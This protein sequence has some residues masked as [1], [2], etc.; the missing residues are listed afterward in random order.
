MTKR[1][2]FGIC[3]LLGLGVFM[4][5]C[6]IIK[7]VQ[8][9][10]IR[11]S[12]D[13]TCKLLICLFGR[14]LLTDFVERGIAQL[15]D[16]VKVSIPVISYLSSPPPALTSSKHRNVG[17]HHHPKHTSSLASLSPSLAIVH[18]PLLHPNKHPNAQ[19]INAA[20]RPHTWSELRHRT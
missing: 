4:G 19:Q 17:H 11:D 12:D 2:K 5:I 8:L 16:V 3:I 9:D 14:L 7:A 1:L 13:S 6:A 18:R 10:S 15:T 20:K